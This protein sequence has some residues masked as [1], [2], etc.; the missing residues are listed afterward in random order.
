MKNLDNNFIDLIIT[1]PPYFNVKDYSQYKSVNDYMNQ[2]KDIFTIAYDKLKQSRMCIIN[3]SPVLVKRESRNKQ[4]YR[5]PLPFYFV[6]MMESIGYEFLEDII[7]EKPEGSVPNRN[8]GFYKHR[9]PVAYKPN[10]VCEYILVFKKP[11]PFL[12]DK[13]LKNHSLVEDGYERT[14]IWRINPKNKSWH[15]A[16]FPDELV[17]KLIKY[18]SYENDIVYDPFAGSGTVGIIGEKLNRN[19]ILSELKTEYY[20][21]MIDENNW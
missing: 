11:A 21:K 8:G 19:V 4:S 10:T 1:S 12:I 2:M 3:I 9:K 20:N 17:E 15:P 16:P 14:N 6:P 13:I 5:I 18:Y 7:W